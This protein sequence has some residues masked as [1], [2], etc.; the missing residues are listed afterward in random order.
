M[1]PVYKRVLLKI[2][3]E[4]LAGSDKFGINEEMTRK[5]AREIKQI[6]D[7]GVE[8]AI[9]VGGGNLT[10][11]IRVVHDGRKEVHRLDQRRVVIDHI[12]AGV[13]GLVEAHDQPRV[14]PR[15]EILQ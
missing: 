8:V 1:K 12:H 6:H 9:V 2:S 11:Q 5:V 15:P 4:A 7:L 13:V 10:E 3:G 14:G